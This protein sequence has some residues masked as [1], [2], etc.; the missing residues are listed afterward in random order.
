MNTF[1]L[2]RVE[3]PSLP[4]QLLVILMP[5]APTLRGGVNDVDFQFTIPVK[6]SSFI[7]TIV[8][9]TGSIYIIYILC[10]GI[11]NG[12]GTKS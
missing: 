3:F 10:T 9:I 2:Y 7:N 11:R 6:I 1:Y 4:I 5:L 12:K 8:A